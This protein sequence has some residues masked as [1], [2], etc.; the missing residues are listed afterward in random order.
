M[1]KNMKLGVRIGL[2]F[3]VALFFLVVTG[4][5]SVSNLKT[6][7]QGLKTV[8]EDRVVPLKGLKAVADAYAVN[9]I[10]AINKTN[11]GLM[12]AEDALKGTQDA[13]RLIKKEWDAYMSTELTA[14]ENTLAH[15]AENLFALA[16]Q[17]IQRLEAA[18]KG[19]TGNIKGQL[20]EFDGPL[21]ANIDPIGGKV[22]EL[23]ELQLRVAEQVYK[24]ASEE[25]RNTLLLTIAVILIA[26]V[27]SALLG[28]MIT[29]AVMR[30]LGGE[31]DFVADLA[32]KVAIGDLST[33]ID[34]KA[35]DTSTV[36]SAMKRM[37]ESIQA[38]VADAT[39]L[40]VA[41]IDGRLA[42]RADT[43]KHQGDFRRIVEGVNDTLDAVIGPLNVAA[44]YVDNIAKG[45]IPVKI[46]D[47]YKGDFNVL[48][49][50]L[51]TCIDALNALVADANMLSLAA[52]EG[53]LDTRADVSKHAGDFRKLVQ[54]INDA[55][56]NIAEPMKVT[57]DYI[58]QIA[59]GSIPTVITTNYKGEYRVIRDNLNAL[60]K[61]ANG[62]LTQTDIV[63]QA[64]ALG[65]LDKRANADLFEGGWNQLVKGFNDAFVNVAEPLKV[66]SGYIEQIAKGVI[67]QPIT[68]DYKGEY[69]VIRD[70]L[71]SLIKTASGLL[72]QTDI[73]IQAAAVGQLD[74]S[75]NADLFEGGWN[76]LVKG[77][78]DAFVNVAEPLK[79]T[80]GYIDQIAKGVIPQP[81]TTDYKGEYLVIRDNLNGLVKLMGDLLTQTDIV[82]Q[83]A[84]N[85]ELD[86]R[87]NAGMFQ[88]GWNQLVEGVN[89]T[90]DGIIL[91]VNEA[92]GVLIEMEKGDLTRI[93]NGNYKGQ[94]KD[95]KDTVNNTIA[96]LSQ[97][98]CE[99]NDAASNIASV[100]EELSATAQSMSQATSE[101][102]AS[103]EETSASVEQMSASINQNTE[104][105]KVTDGMA[106]QASSEAVQ[107][108]EAVKET[109]SAMKSIAGKIGIIDDIAYQT[110]LLALNAAIEAARAGEHGRGFAVVAAEVRKLAERSQIAA[111]EIGELAGSSVEMAESA[112]KL[113]DA[114]VPSIKKTSDL[115]QE[116]AAASEEQSSGVGQINTAM[117]QL[118]KITQ[119]N[120]GSSE[121]LAATSEEMTGQAAQLQDLIS[122]F[123]V[124]NSR[125][126][127]NT[128]S[129][130]PIAKVKLSK[131]P[132]KKVAA[133][134]RAAN[135]I[136]F[137]NF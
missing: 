78:N 66:T 85:G 81:I 49:N 102:A 60:I 120:A 110:N 24:T 31:P 39:V 26:V 91:P 65:Q 100:S 118:N 136:E 68:T 79:V 34:L 50:N 35:G 123:T 21:Y 111:Q 137:V 92:V 61:T 38:L 72:T 53:Q 101:Q 70:N 88:G 43:S 74:K 67:P 84:A 52:A 64:A 132:V 3:L 109:V 33:Q 69:L 4:V 86:K 29:R 45:A 114:I 14:E 89:K 128:V 126:A 75:A 1:F 93:V 73:V 87:A 90:L 56:G 40:S 113:L 18:L 8:Y 71:N 62:L 47:T 11:A 121:E 2:G 5:Y 130:P 58:E 22:A 57:S 44:D 119:Q 98:I 59:K 112:G 108:G 63:I 127:R 94:L 12:N 99:V 131:P 20:A 17:D 30:Q 116:I 19:K 134:K 122:F 27:I 133:A 23:I 25:Y 115:V 42:T 55:I 46:T 51:N 54:G 6:A 16:N 103:V 107:G 124:D 15:E 80:S 125:G 97:V 48:K 9:V 105:A 7:N 77:F 117:E 82:I 37:T 95:F 76:Q 32:N 13:G 83:A 28:F 129:T 36:V 96:K 10:D 104:N 41:A 135:E 106:T